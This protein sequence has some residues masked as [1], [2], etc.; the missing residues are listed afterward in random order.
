MSGDSLAVTL[1][2]WSL[3]VAFVLAAIPVIQWRR[4]ILIIVLFAFAVVFAAFGF[5]WESIAAAVPKFGELMHAV[6]ASKLAWFSA[7]LAVIFFPLL[8]A[9]HRH[10]WLR[11]GR[12][13]AIE[14]ARRDHSP[15]AS[16]IASVQIAEPEAKAVAKQERIPVG[17][18][19]TP[20]YLVGLYRENTG[21]QATKLTERV[22]GK[23]MRVSGRVEE[24]LP[25]G[26]TS[27]QLT[28]QR[29][30][31]E[32]MYLH[33]RA[34][35]YMRLRE[36]WIDRVAMLRRGDEVTVY[37]QLDQVDKLAIHLM[38]CEIEGTDSR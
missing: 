2:F 10:G 36:S 1:F 25:T 34:T 19:I 32:S 16:P 23:W 11:N 30:P 14:E 12:P 27:A 20:E 37:G 13:R 31:D 18:S 6:A 8:D 24:V 26:P 5:W 15:P 9:A 28:F 3:M 7:F 35:I 21:I 38:S 4:N 33:E 29:R 17:P 22:I